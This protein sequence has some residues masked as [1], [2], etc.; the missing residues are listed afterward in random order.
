VD[1]GNSSAANTYVGNAGRNGKAQYF[2]SAIPLKA[3]SVGMTVIQVCS[4]KYFRIF[5]E[6]VVKEPRIEAQKSKRQRERSKVSSGPSD[7]LFHFVEYRLDVGEDGRRVQ[8]GI[9]GPQDALLR[10]VAGDRH[11]LEQGT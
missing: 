6:K 8:G 1:V 2:Q 9:H 7:G 4:V 5:G 3:I 11:S 10:V